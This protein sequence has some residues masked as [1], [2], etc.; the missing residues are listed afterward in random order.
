M[1]RTVGD[2]VADALA[3]ATAD[4]RVARE[5]LERCRDGAEVALGAD[6]DRDRLLQVLRELRETAV[7]VVGE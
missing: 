4:A 2:T 5:A 1:N 6:L 7:G 3:A